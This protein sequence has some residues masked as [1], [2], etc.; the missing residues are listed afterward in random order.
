MLHFVGQLSTLYVM[1][2]EPANEIAYLHL[3]YGD[4]EGNYSEYTGPGT[5]FSGHQITYRAT[6]TTYKG[7]GSTGSPSVGLLVYDCATTL[8]GQTAENISKS[9]TVPS[10]M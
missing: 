6:E 4:C 3:R 1:I 10:H 2:E 9:H 5:S 8:G 7:R